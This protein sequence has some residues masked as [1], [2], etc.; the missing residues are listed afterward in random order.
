MNDDQK[1]RT[2]AAPATRR[3]PRPL[4]R[5]RLRA[6]RAT[7][8]DRGDRAGRP[9]R[10]QARALTIVRRDDAARAGDKVIGRALRAATKDRRA[11]TMRVDKDGGRVL[12]APSG[13]HQ[14]KLADR[15]EARRSPVASV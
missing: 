5:A 11:G 13:K 15:K 14:K 9:T 8:V 1:R 4:R 10:A 6:E 2:V 12:H 3:E 7:M